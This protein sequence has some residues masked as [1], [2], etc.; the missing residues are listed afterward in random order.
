MGLL[1]FTRPENISTSFKD[2]DPEPHP[3]AD[4]QCA[5]CSVR[6]HIMAEGNSARWAKQATYCNVA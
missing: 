5:H 4:I 1:T 2:R 6:F 3:S